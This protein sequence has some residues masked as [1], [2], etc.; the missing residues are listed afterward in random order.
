MT[1]IKISP[2]RPSTSALCSYAGMASVAQRAYNHDFVPGTGGPYPAGA[3]VIACS[4]TLGSGRMCYAAASRLLRKWKMHEGSATTGISALYDGSTP[5]PGSA[6]VTWA[7]MAPLVWVLNPCRVVRPAAGLA[8]P[9]GGG[10]CV[11]RSTAV[12][13]ATTEGHLIAGVEHMRVTFS[14][15]GTVAFQVH[16]VSHGAG[17]VGRALFPLLAPAQ[18][19]FFHEQCRCMREQ[20]C[21]ADQVR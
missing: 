16:S 21:D 14:R 1:S 3:R 15:D 9:P 5:L 6:V 19:R 20:L 12:A 17:F 13:Y 2:D 8:M 11:R 18:R 4:T 7:R 10:Q